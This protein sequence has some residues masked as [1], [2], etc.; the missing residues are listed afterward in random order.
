MK[1]KEDFSQSRNFRC[2]LPNQSI[3]TTKY[4]NRQADSW[5]FKKC[6]SVENNDEPFFLE[7]NKIKLS[8]RPDPNSREKKNLKFSKFWKKTEEEKQAKKIIGTKNHQDLEIITPKENEI[9]KSK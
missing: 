3:S 1:S 2:S 5:K 6:Q 9:V 7:A 8:D 4:V